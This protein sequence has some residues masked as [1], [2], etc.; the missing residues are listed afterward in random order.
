MRG[1]RGLSAVGIAVLAGWANVVGAAD[2]K[3]PYES[4]MN[5][6]VAEVL[7]ADKISGP[8]YKIRDT[9]FADGYMYS[10]RAETDYG[11]FDVTGDYALRK[12][13]KEIQAIAK[14]REIKK[15]EVYAKALKES[16]TSPLVF[17]KDMINQPTETLAGIPKGVGKLFSNAVTGLKSKRDPSQDSRLAAALSVSS[18]KREY[19]YA[20]G[21]DPYSS[22]KVL[23]EELNSL[24]WAGAAG[25]LTVSAA[26]MPFGG[27]AA[28]VISYTRLAQTFNDLLKEKN[29]EE[30]REIN[31]RK[32]AAMGVSQDLAK[33]FLDHAAFTPRHD[34]IIVG[35]LEMMGGA[36]GKSEFVKYALKATDEENANFIQNM[37]ETLRGYHQGVAAIREIRLISGVIVAQAANQ[38]VVVPFPLDH[39]VWTAN[40]ETVTKD[41][42]AK[43]KQAGWNGKLELWVSGTLSPL[44]KENLGRLG[45]GFAERVADR[46]EYQY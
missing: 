30:L 46:M 26:L 12:L 39:G 36:K 44:A 23:Q 40:A 27:P 25:S 20:F 10:Y 19:A 5:R 15:G 4:Y 9:V 14:M 3:A 24:G 41:L 34:T 16:A 21:V 28:M 43:A 31:G 37:A 35:S 38:T 33:K 22:N 11:V 29:P 18:H 17:A 13:L 8:H 42:K 1:R 45:I 7:P 2:Y 6:P 32:L